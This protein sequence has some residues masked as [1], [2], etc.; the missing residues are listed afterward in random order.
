KKIQRDYTERRRAL[1]DEKNDRG[2]GKGKPDGYI[3]DRECDDYSEDE[4]LHAALSPLLA[5]PM[6]TMS[7]SRLRL[8]RNISPAA[9]GR[10][11]D[12]QLIL[13][14]TRETAVSS[15]IFLVSSQP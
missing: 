12:I 4:P 1:P 13:T 14:H 3:D 6:N 5:S 15:P 10:T 7:M 11:L 8:I 9:I 2:N